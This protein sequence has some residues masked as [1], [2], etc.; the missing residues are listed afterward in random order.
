[1]VVVQVL[2][3]SSLCKPFQKASADGHG[4]NGIGVLGENGMQDEQQV[5]A[6]S[7]PWQQ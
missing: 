1:M 7:E 5:P 3:G 4:V 2:L 6:L